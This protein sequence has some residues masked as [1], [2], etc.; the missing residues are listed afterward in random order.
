MRRARFT[1]QYAGSSQRGFSILNDVM[2]PIG[3]V[4]HL[5]VRQALKAKPGSV[6]SFLATIQSYQHDSGEPDF[7]LADIQVII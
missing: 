5:W 7:T 6:V 2:P 1:A 3:Y 4:Q